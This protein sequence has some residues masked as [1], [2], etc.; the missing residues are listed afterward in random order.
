MVAVNVT[1]ADFSDVNTTGAQAAVKW[2]DA[3]VKPPQ[4]PEEIPLP[5][6]WLP[7]LIAGII[8]LVVILIWRRRKR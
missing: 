7:V 2:S 3:K 4:L 8:T 1:D 6:P 5:P